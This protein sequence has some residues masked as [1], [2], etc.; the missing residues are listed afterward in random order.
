MVVVLVMDTPPTEATLRGSP[1]ESESFERTFPLI[2]IGPCSDTDPVS[3]VASG[4]EAIVQISRRFLVNF[5][6]GNPIAA[7]E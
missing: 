1:A 2:V 5:W 4:G 7:I 6:L 3:G